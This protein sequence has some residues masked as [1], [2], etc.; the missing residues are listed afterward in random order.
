MV[1]MTFFGQNK[2]LENIFLQQTI[3]SQ[4]SSQSQSSN[5]LQIILEPNIS[6][7]PTSSSQI[8]SQISLSSNSNSK[9][10][11]EQI[12]SS[13]SSN[14]SSI[15]FPQLSGTDFQNI[16]ESTSYKNVIQDKNKPTIFTGEDESVEKVN[17]YVQNIAENRGYK[18]RL[19]AV[20]EYL[21]PIDGQRLQVESKNAW[22]KLKESAS[23]DGINL[24]LVS[25]YRSIGEQRGLFVGDLSAEYPVSD[26]LGGNIDSELNLIMDTRSIPGY[27]R[28]HTGYTMDIGCGNGDLTS[29][30]NTT[31]YE[32]IRSNNFQKAKEFGLIPSYPAGVV[33]QGPK[34]EEW[35]FVWV[36]EIQNIK[37]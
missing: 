5:I 6:S 9:A 25:G 35:E 12:T 33:K 7:K 36:G 22:I 32:W 13:I 24:V 15:I 29:F 16:Y 4:Q 3:N 28:H 17:Q 23:K 8:S 10:N 2:G 31:C 18:R 1:N 14:I 27:S 20:E 34:P 37:N 21:V 19:Q 26:I 11:S 30:K